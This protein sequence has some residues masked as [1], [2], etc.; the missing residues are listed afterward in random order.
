MKDAIVDC[1][2]SENWPVLWLR[3]HPENNEVSALA[4]GQEFDELT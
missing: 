3:F 2:R 4:N 1:G